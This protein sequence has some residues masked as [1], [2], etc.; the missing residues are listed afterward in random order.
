ML[1]LEVLIV[2]LLGIMAG[3]FTGLTPG[4][5]INLVSILLLSLSPLLLQ[6]TSAVVLCCF[7]I[8]MAVTH[9]FLD[10][11][12][13]IFLGAPDSDQV[14]NVLPGHKLLLEGKGFEAVKLTVIGSLLCLIFAVLLVPALI[15]FVGLVYP[16]LNKYMGFL[17][18]GITLFMVFKD[19]NRFKNLFLFLISGVLGIIVL[20]IP[21]LKD[22]LF[23][24]LSG[25]FGTSMLAVS[26]TQ[27]VNIPEQKIEE[28]L[29]LPK[30]EIAKAVIGGSIAGTM[31]G[32]FPGLGPSQGAVL[33]TQFLRKM[34]DYGFMILVGGLNTVNFIISLVAL[35]VID[36]AR[37][38]AVIVMQEL[39]AIDSKTLLIFLA[40]VLIVGAAATF[41]TLKITKIFSR[42]FRYVKYEDV[43]QYV[44]MLIIVL[45]FYFSGFLGLVV[46]A[47][48][49][50]VGIMASEMNIARNHAMGCLLLPVLLFFL[51]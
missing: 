44:I 50:L 22:P 9:T 7:I 6:H 18:L 46:L 28:T 1:A 40:V 43:V 14:L 20:S 26:L 11:I 41:L 21:N 16:F 49:T 34:T 33:S 38:G 42:L 24:L 23:P 35:L 37:N 39:I 25:L 13:S 48:A 12:P 5:H 27:K 4:V 31:T 47:T 8:A 2:V 17:L 15:P 45:V 3:I 29:H 30:K 32:F 19:K 51:L 10:A 36:K